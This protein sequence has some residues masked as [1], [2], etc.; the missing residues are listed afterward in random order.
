MGYG[1]GANGVSSTVNGP[2]VESWNGLIER[3]MVRLGVVV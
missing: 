2:C 1:R 3:G